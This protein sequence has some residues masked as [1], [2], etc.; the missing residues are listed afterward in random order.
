MKLVIENVSKK[1]GTH[2]LF[3]KINKTLQQGESW[4][5]TGPNGS[6]KSTFMQ[7]IAGAIQPTEGKVWFEISPQKI[8]TIE[9]FFGYTSIVAPYMQLIEELTV[10]ELVSIHFKLKPMKGNC[11]DFLEFCHLTS[12][13]HK[14]I[15][16]LSSGMK[17][18]L[19]LGLT[20]FSKAPIILL[21]EPCSNLDNQF[22][23]WYL[24]NVKFLN[25][26]AEKIIIIFSNSKAEY[27]W[28]ED[29]LHLS[30]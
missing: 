8:V 22:F 24:E 7:I 2:Y 18:R 25:Q 19:K 10:I 20:F 5:V 13:K 9:N 1:F 16:K 30:L 17:Q 27:D 4:A 14:S 26:Q 12:H 29:I 15:N 21:D 28:C 11:D 6:G 3:K 23:S